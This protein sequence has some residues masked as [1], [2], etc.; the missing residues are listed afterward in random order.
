MELTDEVERAIQ[1]ASRNWS[2][3]CRED[4][5]QEARLALL[6]LDIDPKKARAYARWAML[7]AWRRLYKRHEHV[8][9]LEHEPTT[10]DVSECELQEQFTRARCL[11]DMR[12]R[13]G[14]REV[15]KKVRKKQPLWEIVPA[16]YREQFVRSLKS[17]AQE[18]I[19]RRL[20]LGDSETA[21]ADRFGLQSVRGQAA[22]LRGRAREFM[23]KI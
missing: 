10:T 5:V 2:T 21:V 22:T 9:L 3:N 20:L 1:L 19:A 8:A 4:M 11:S 18:T 7:D 12:E 13:E 6:Q 16:E 14:E 15:E 23:S 17:F